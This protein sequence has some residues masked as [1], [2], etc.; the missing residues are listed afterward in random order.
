VVRQASVE[1]G[2]KRKSGDPIAGTAPE[3][4]AY[5]APKLDFAEYGAMVHSHAVEF[6]MW[7]DEPFDDELFAAHAH[8][9]AVRRY[10]L[11]ARAWGV[12]SVWPVGAKAERQLESKVHF[13]VP[14]YPS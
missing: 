3:R 8:A 10:G 4:P 7:A 5:V 6:R 9:A 1:Y 11:H 13:W 14:I 2:G 12:E